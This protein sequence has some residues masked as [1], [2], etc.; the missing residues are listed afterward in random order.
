MKKRLLLILLCII[1]SFS[2]SQTNQ[3]E[4]DYLQ[5]IFGMGKKE[6]F[7]EMIDLKN[8]NEAS[9]WPIYDDYEI[10]RKALGKEKI[11]TLE[12]YAENYDSLYDN[13]IDILIKDA[14]NVSAKSDKLINT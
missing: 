11:R 5:S 6:A 7:A 12:T 10:K 8:T 13:K 4:V 3:E 9:F 2:F 1:T 14:I